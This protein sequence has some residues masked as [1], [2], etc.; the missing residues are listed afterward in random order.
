MNSRV[1]Y[2]WRLEVEV[3]RILD[4]Q[5]YVTTMDNSLY[6]Q[7]H[8]QPAVFNVVDLVAVVSVFSQNR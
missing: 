4:Q 7:S 5:L 1:E 6:N 2:P 8:R 3:S